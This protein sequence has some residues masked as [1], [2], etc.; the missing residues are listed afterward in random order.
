METNETN[1]IDELK[2][3]ILE[4]VKEEIDKIEIL[5]GNDGEQGEQGERGYD[6]IDGVD[7]KDG[8]NG[9]DGKDGKNGIDGVDGQD[10]EKGEKGD[11]GSLDE[12]EEIRDKL[13]LLKDD[14]R[15][16]VTAIKG[17]DKLIKDNKPKIIGSGTTVITARE[18]GT[19][20]GYDI[21]DLNFIGATVVKN[22][23]SGVDVTISGG[24]TDHSALTGLTTSGHQASIIVTSTTNFNKN[25]SSADNTVQKALDTLDNMVAGTGGGGDI[26]GGSASSVYL[27]AQNIDGG[28]A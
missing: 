21:R 25:L 28:T 8:K 17:I 15:L 4:I 26:E 23:D 20:V 11:N 5:D 16:D 13:Q 7:G 10:G 12:P 22:S 24:A 6:G 18:N 2:D 27:I 9:K 14:E 3:E 19:H 1:L